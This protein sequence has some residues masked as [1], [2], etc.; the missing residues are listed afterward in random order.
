MSIKIFTFYS[1]CFDRINTYNN[2]NNHIIRF[3]ENI[4]SLNR[5]LRWYESSIIRDVN[6]SCC[7]IFLNYYYSI[8]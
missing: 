5:R 3:G 4:K 6:N 1:F 7:E 2:E 8:T